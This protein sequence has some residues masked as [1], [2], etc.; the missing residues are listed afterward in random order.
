LRDAAQLPVQ[1]LDDAGTQ[2][3]ELCENR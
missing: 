2:G 1:R 3:T